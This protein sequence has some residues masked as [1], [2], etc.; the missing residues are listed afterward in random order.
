MNTKN[1]LFLLTLICFYACTSDKKK[2]SSSNE[3]T[4]QP[5]EK[6]SEKE[7][8]SNKIDVEK[9]IEI[10]RNDFNDIDS[11][12]ATLKKK[13]TTLQENRLS[14]EIEGFYDANKIV[15]VVNTEV[16]GHSVVKI[17]YYLKDDKLFFVYETRSDEA[18][19][20]GPFT[21]REL[22]TYIH[23]GQL[24]K[25][26]KKEKTF[27]KDEDINIANVPNID[28][29][30]EVVKSKGLIKLYNKGYSKRINQLIN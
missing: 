16:L 1:L 14:V 12:L 25:A 2:S 26:L 6:V 27:E 24:L 10:I 29:T 5:T 18:S 23:K 17:S 28:I 7:I 30:E 13:S 21:I 20:N 3:I 22:R 19:V 4:E 9:Q 8:I 11:K 15:K